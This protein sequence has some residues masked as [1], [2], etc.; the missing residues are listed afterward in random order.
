MFNCFSHSASFE[1][2]SASAL[3]IL[4]SGTWASKPS[5]RYGSAYGP[6]CK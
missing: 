4:L 1:F 2:F 3:S 5:R 6:V